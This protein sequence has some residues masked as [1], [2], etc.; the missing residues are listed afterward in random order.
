MRKKAAHAQSPAAQTRRVT[1][2]SLLRFS[3]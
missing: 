3:T 2:N 1:K